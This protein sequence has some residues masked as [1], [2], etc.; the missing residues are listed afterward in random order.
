MAAG[1]CLSLFAQ[2]VGDPIVDH[3]MPFLRDNI[4]HPTSWQHRDAA[5]LAFG[6]ILEGPSKEKL[7]PLVEMVVPLSNHF[8]VPRFLPPLPRY[9]LAF[10]RPN[11]PFAPLL[12]LSGRLLQSVP[13]MLSAL[14]DPSLQVKDT[15]AWTLGQIC[16]L[17]PASV[18]SKLF[19]LMGAL[20]E[21]LSEAPRVANNVCWAIHN[22]AKADPTATEK[23]TNHLSPY[24]PKLVEKLMETTQR[25]PLTWCGRIA[26]SR[27]EL[28]VGSAPRPHRA[29]I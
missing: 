29:P 21:A 23:S 6:S 22:I 2:N 10:S 5:M 19:E 12:P 13:R 7:A 24:F 3:V 4:N 1:H 26:A 16:E 20:Y 18:G 17:H 11:Y 27:R 15:A 9:L 8:L 25:S 14:K 28:D